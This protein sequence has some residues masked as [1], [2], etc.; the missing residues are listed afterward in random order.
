MTLYVQSVVLDNCEEIPASFSRGYDVSRD[1]VSGSTRTTNAQH[2]NDN[3]AGD[4][5]NA[6]AR[7]YHRFSACKVVR[8]A[9]SVR[10]CP[11]SSHTPPISSPGP[12]NICSCL[13]YFSLHQHKDIQISSCVD[14][15]SMRSS[16]CVKGMDQ[17]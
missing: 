7:F 17:A 15:D 2:D 4:R 10:C 16:P 14:A 12:L 1:G 6:D 9:N 5:C 13:N 3:I 8:C 11:P